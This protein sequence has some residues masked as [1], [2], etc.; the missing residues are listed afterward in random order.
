MPLQRL[1]FRSGVNRESTTYANEGGYYACDKVRFRSGFPEKLGGWIRL[2]VNS[3][4]GTCR[5]LW[6]WA[7]LDGTNLLGVGT[8]LKYYVESGGNYNDITP[9]RATVV[10]AANAF[11]TVNGSTTVTVNDAA[12]GFFANDFVTISGSGAVNGIPAGEINGEHQIVSATA[13]TWTFTVTT[14]ATSSGT[15]GAATFAYQLNVGLENFVAGGGWGAGFFGRGT[16]GSGVSGSG[17]G[18]GQQMRL[19]NHSNFGQDLVFGPRSAGI[20]Y[21]AFDLA[22]PRGV[23]L[24]TRPGASDVPT[25]QNFI[26]VT[27]N[28][29]LVVF[30]T[31]AIGSAV[32]DPMLVRWAD[33]ESAV[34][35]T[36]A[37]TN[38][39]GEQRLA[40]GS[41]IITAS[42]TRQEVLVW[43]DAALYSMQYVG[44]DPVWG[45]NILADNTSIISPMSVTT[46]SNVTY[47][48]GIDKF[49][50]Y[51][52]RVEPLPCALRQY[53][54]GDI[55]LSQ[56]FQVV[57][58]SNEGFNE[59]W[60]HYCSAGSEEIDRY[61]IYNY[62]ERVWYYGNMNRTAWLDSPLR[63]YPM[64]ASN[65]TILYHEASVDDESTGSPVA[66]ESYVESADF[67]I[68]DGH[69]FGFVWRIIP[70]VSFDGST[71]TN[72]AVTFTVRPR[73]N[74]GAAYGTDDDPAVTRISTVPVEQYTQYAYVRMRGRQMALRVGSTALGVQWQLGAPR[75]DV[76]EDGKK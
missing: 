36:P 52:G 37:I 14:A 56:G 39:A 13:T 26:L 61:V 58:G 59:V 54:F 66:I 16:W 4:L 2:S 64:G 29:F 23:A 48:M 70:D 7:T 38:Q 53:I 24:S 19:W 35:W 3:F 46:V 18:A 8:H 68:G 15:T 12:G 25:V 51:T 73:R 72:P 45:F 75:L 63:S 6:N 42:Q 55:N 10:I 5:T 50:I 28:R 41:Q 31:N 40:R 57:S 27:D 34:N 47:W 21:W 17:V 33:Q 76:R 11:T 22:F 30:G 20:Y 71:A 69:K 49:Y 60:W 43:T 9:L 32:L 67:D 44:P 65:N 74:P 1:Q 62:L